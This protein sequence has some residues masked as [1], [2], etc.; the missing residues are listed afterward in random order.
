MTL[1]TNKSL[2]AISIS[3]EKQNC[4]SYVVKHTAVERGCLRLYV[5]TVEPK[6]DVDYYIFLGAEDKL[7]PKLAAQIASDT[8]DLLNRVVDDLR[9]Q[10]RFKRYTL[11][12][13]LDKITCL[14][15]NEMDFLKLDNKRS[16]STEFDNEV[17]D[18]VIDLMVKNTKYEQ[19]KP[20]KDLVNRFSRS[21]NEDKKG[22]APNKPQPSAK[23]TVHQ[24]LR[25]SSIQKAST[26][27][28]TC[29]QSTSRKRIQIRDD[30]EGN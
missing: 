1:F 22:E 19:D 12:F 7:T 24:L 27:S 3:T 16:S 28:D 9:G 6:V 8:V 11:N 13:G 30:D 21:L 14:N 4:L 29:G 10:K 15:A 2:E 26:Q 20:G 17:G 25:P 5:F 18:N 23:P